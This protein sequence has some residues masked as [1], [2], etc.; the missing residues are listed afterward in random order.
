MR[1]FKLT[2]PSCLLDAG[3]YR[4][5]TVTWIMKEFD[6]EVQLFVNPKFKEMEKEAKF[7]SGT[8]KGKVKFLISS[9]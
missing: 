5:H 1:Y 6:Y 3:I 4:L 9:I 7:Y 8:F 2:T